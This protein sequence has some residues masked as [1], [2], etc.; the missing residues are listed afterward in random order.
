MRRSVLELQ[1]RSFSSR[2]QFLEVRGSIKNWDG[3]LVRDIRSSHSPPSASPSSLKLRVHGASK[4]CDM[5]EIDKHVKRTFPH[6]TS[7]IRT[8][9][10]GPPAITRLSDGSCSSMP[11]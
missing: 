11:S 10:L 7:S 3:K 9:T 1:I 6:S 5:M 8:E 2:I 4:D